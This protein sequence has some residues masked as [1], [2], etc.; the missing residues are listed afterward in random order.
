MKVAIVIALLVPLLI[1][2]YFTVLGFVS[3]SS[4]PPG[5][6][7]DR[8]S[9]CSQKPNCVSSEEGTDSQHKVEPFTAGALTIKQLALLV[10]GI[11]GKVVL[12]NNE[13]LA[14]EFSSSLFGF[15]DDLELRIDHDNDLLHIR[16]ASR[17][18]HSD[19]GVNR[20]RVDQ[21]RARLAEQNP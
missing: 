7:N 13:Y 11:G 19:F 14:A 2:G 5:M 9:V 1:A 3:R 15:V 4:Q 21:I 10:E 17:V 16:S 8:L 6:D 20:K 12:V 18:G